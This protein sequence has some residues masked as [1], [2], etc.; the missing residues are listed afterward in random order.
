MT[1]PAKDGT[2]LSLVTSPTYNELLSMLGK[3]SL[4][5]YKSSTTTQL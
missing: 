3:L 5:S 2:Y 1:R 4:F